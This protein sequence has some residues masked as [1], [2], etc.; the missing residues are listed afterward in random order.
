MFNLRHVCA[1]WIE[2]VFVCVYAVEIGNKIYKNVLFA[3]VKFSY[4]SSVPTFTHLLFALNMK[5][6]LAFF[7]TCLWL[8]TNVEVT[9]RNINL[10]IAEPP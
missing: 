10:R 2:I 1:E 7:I 4:Q 8:A 9:K 3:S 6:L 5:V